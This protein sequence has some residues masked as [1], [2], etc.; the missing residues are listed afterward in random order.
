MSALIALAALA[1]ATQADA[2]DDA[3]LRDAP[4]A[5]GDAPFWA[6]EFNA[7]IPADRWLCDRSSA[8]EYGDHNPKDSKLDWLDC[9]Q[10]TVDSGLATFTA[11]PGPHTLESGKQAWNAGLLTTE[12]SAEGF[13][14]QTGDYIETRV[15]LPS[16]EGAWP[17][18]WTWKDGGNEIDS[19]E[20]HPDN[21]N[22][23]ELTNHVN[24]SYKYH[25][26]DQA[27]APET[28][29]TLGTKY[30]ADSVTWYV[31]GVEVFS[32]HT[33]VG[34]SWSAYLILNLSVYS[35]VH[36]PGPG[37]GPLTFSADYVRVYR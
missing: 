31:N 36:H 13:R 37:T 1:T 19:F 21:P 27:I 11:Q 12:G 20:Y 4:V 15:R 10:V 32:D 2:A 34:T 3:L 14:V 23:L 33:G 17:A 35:G 25:T 22:L 7:P 24:P 16:G 18:L 8:Y 6:E 9:S 28:W 30:G 5:V 26:D 29:V